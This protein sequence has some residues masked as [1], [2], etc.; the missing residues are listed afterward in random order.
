[1]ASL[2]NW[3]AYIVS[4]TNL[5]EAANTTNRGVAKTANQG[6]V[7]GKFNYEPAFGDSKFGVI[8]Q[9]S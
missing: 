4:Y 8:K 7:K 2:Q 9:T 5:S 1:V 3:I 6:N